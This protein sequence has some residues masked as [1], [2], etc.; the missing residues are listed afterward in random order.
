MGTL[1]PAPSAFAA[2]PDSGSWTRYIGPATSSTQRSYGYA[3][4]N[5]NASPKTVYLEAEGYA[6]SSGYCETVLF[7]WLIG[8][9]EG[10]SHF[11]ARAVRDC[12]STSYNATRRFNE[13]TAA[14]RVVGVQKL[15]VCYGVNNTR[16]TCSDYP[17]AS[18]STVPTDWRTG[19]GITCISWIRRNSD[20]TT[21]TNSGGDPRLCGS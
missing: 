2:P 20:T 10:S 1:G 6:L 14:F 21:T 19:N 18:T 8:S 12:R 5:S 7:D 17:D 11:D 16:G 3:S 15:G 4:W 9:G 13:T